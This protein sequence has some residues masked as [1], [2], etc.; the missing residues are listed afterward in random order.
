[1]D[2]VGVTRENAWI[3]LGLDGAVRI[4]DSEPSEVSAHVESPVSAEAGQ[5]E[6]VAGAAPEAWMQDTLEG[7]P[8]MPSAEARPVPVEAAS[9]ADPDAASREAGERAADIL[10]LAATAEDPDAE[11][12]PAWAEYRAPG[13]PEKFGQPIGYI[14]HDPAYEVDPAGALY[15]IRQ[16]VA[17]A[18]QADA[19]ELAD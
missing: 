3:Q 11:P 5:P 15:S 9:A 18:S 13:I 16:P 2:Q 8:A 4:P 1:L 10:S 6:S 7:F 17:G 19:Q 14:R 12:D